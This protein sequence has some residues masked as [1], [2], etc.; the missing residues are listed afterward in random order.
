MVLRKGQKVHEPGG[1]LHFSLA[2]RTGGGSLYPARKQGY[3][4]DGLLPDS[5]ALLHGQW[6]LPDRRH[7]QLKYLDRSI[8]S[9]HRGRQGRCRR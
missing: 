1:S 6:L 9:G 5:D 3:G 8:D 7:G 2:K 4:Q